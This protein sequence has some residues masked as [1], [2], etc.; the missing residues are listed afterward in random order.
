VRARC[1]WDYQLLGATDPVLTRNLRWLTGYRHP[2]YLVAEIAARLRG[3]VG[4]PVALIDAAHTAGDP[5]ATLPVLYHLLWRHVL[6]A[7]LTVPRRTAT[8]VAMVGCR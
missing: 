1:G 3:V 5:I 2:R 4:E 6:W 8:P 7:D